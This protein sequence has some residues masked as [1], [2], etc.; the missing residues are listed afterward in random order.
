[1]WDGQLPLPPRPPMS[2]ARPQ[3]LSVCL[4]LPP[5]AAGRGRLGMYVWEPHVIVIAVVVVIVCG[6]GCGGDEDGE[7]NIFSYHLL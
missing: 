5:V 3:L 1:M 6:G 7:D 2:P 4:S